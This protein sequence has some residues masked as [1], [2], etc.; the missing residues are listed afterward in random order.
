MMSLNPNIVQGE[1]E[2]L[3]LETFCNGVNS[4]P[5][6]VRQWISAHPEFVKR[7]CKNIGTEKRKKW[8][9]HWEGIAAY[10]ATKTSNTPKIKPLE[11][12]G[13]RDA[14]QIMA[15]KVNSQISKKQK[16][17]L[18]DIDK[19][20]E[21]SR[22]LAKY[23]ETQMQTIKPLELPPSTKPEIVDRLEKIEKDLNAPLEPTHEQRAFLND[24]VR[25]YCINNDI[26]FFRI[27]RQVNSHVGKA[28]IH[29]YN[30]A[31]YRKAL[32]YLKSLYQEVGLDWGI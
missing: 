8:E 21:I 10:I 5:H 29:A 32:A 17:Q 16:Q 2:W 26:P 7:Y 4:T 18:P 28:G 11:L 14:K 3:T 15:D 30:F 19:L 23:A 27:W 6:A 31:E 9:I 25:F 12:R 20:L 1:A 22:N 24:R 13:L